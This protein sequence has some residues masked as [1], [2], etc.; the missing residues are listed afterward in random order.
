MILLLAA[1]ALLPEP[2]PAA[3]PQNDADVPCAFD[4]AARL[5]GESKASAEAVA[6]EVVAQCL[7]PASGKGDADMDVRTFRVRAAAIAMVNRR[8]GL[9]GQPADAPIRLPSMERS[10]AHNFAIPDEIAPA[11][12]PY[13]ECLVASMGL[14]MHDEHGKLVTPPPGVAR[15]SDCAGVRERAARDADRLLI[16]EGKKNAAE[17]RALIDTTLTAL[18][19]FVHPPAPT[20][21]PA[22]SETNAPNR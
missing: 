12:V 9:D 2:V 6:D 16:R 15:G 10:E 22:A 20:P 19:A 21:A 4:K 5:A 3:G 13:F 7:P 14:P 11:I 8:R 17:R 1:L 18:T